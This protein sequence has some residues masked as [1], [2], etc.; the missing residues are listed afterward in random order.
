MRM[1]KGKRYFISFMDTR[2]DFEFWFVGVGVF[3]SIDKNDRCT[4]EQHYYFRLPNERS[5]ASFPASSIVNLRG[6]RLCK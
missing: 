2:L 1:I 6:I 3:V 4:K 5:L